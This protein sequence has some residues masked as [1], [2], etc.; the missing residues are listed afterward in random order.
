MPGLCRIDINSGKLSDKC[1]AVPARKCRRCL[2]LPPVFAV[3]G[4][5]LCLPA[6]TTVPGTAVCSCSSLLQF[7]AAGNESDN[8]ASDNGASDNRSLCQK[9]TQDLCGNSTVQ[10]SGRSASFADS[11]PGQNFA[12]TS[13]RRAR[14]H[15]CQ[16]AHQRLL[17]RAALLIRQYS[18]FRTAATASGTHSKFT[19]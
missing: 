18:C 14:R 6:D 9:Q 10:V 3:P 12:V 5:C 4:C 1:N 15:A 19:N 7:T 2:Q 8:G 13:Q 17:I 11:G 16:S